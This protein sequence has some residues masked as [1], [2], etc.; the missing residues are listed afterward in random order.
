MK[1][2]PI[3]LFIPDLE[4]YLTKSRDLAFSYEKYTKG[5]LAKDFDSLFALLKMPTEDYKMPNIETIRKTFWASS[6]KN[7][8]ELVSA[9]NE[10][11]N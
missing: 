5:I 9:I 2:K 8:S 10:K 11:L 1:D 6:S 3:I 4:D 7:M